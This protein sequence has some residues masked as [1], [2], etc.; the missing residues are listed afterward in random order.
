M[1]TTPFVTKERVDLLKITPP[2]THAEDYSDTVLL[3][4]NVFSDLSEVGIGNNWTI[5][6]S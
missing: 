5:T 3:P 2:A 1:Y 4:N 6:N